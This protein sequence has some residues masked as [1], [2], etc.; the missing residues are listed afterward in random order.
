[1]VLTAAPLHLGLDLDNT[2]V[3]YDAVFL[4]AALELAL[5]PGGFRGDKAAVRA[6]VRTRPEGERQWQRLQAEVYAHRMDQARPMPGAQAFLAR[7][8]NHGIALSIV[9][10]KTRHA[11]A[12][13]GKA[14]LRALAL[15]WLG[16]HGL[17]D[18]TRFGLDARRVHFTDTR[19]EKLRCIAEL[20]CTD[21]VDDLPE[22]LADPAFPL[23][24]RRFLFAPPDRG[25]NALWQELAP[26]LSEV[27]C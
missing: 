19:A 12:D 26:R 10:H 24:V 18:P 21:F 22:V 16:D 6:A 23:G 2:L 11:A 17:L 8:R 25:W 13:P 7:C 3:G 4:A 9:S 14:D 5:V 20:G 1:M 15:D 27:S